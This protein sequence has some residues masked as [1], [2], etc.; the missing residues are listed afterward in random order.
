MVL[1][2]GVRVLHVRYLQENHMELV[3]PRHQEQELKNQLIAIGYIVM[4]GYSPLS[5]QVR[6]ETDEEKRQ[7]QRLL[8]REGAP[9]SAQRKCRAERSCLL[10]EPTGR[11]EGESPC[12]LY[13][14]RAGEIQPRV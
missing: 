6:R 8:R 9:A 1:T 10:R 3:T 5:M 12:R 13:R 14:Q 4:S 11:G 7:A 2:D